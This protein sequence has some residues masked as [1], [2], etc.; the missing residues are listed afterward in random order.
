MLK[1]LEVTIHSV[2][3]RVV[4]KP[5]RKNN[6]RTVSQMGR[7]APTSLTRQNS[8]AFSLVRIMPFR[9]PDAELAPGFLSSIWVHEVMSV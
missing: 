2:S 5:S 8:S 3:L 4:F 9:G 6:G 7:T 1:G